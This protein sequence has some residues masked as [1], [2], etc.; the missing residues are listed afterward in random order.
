MRSIARVAR[1]LGLTRPIVDRRFLANWRGL[2]AGRVGG[3]SWSFARPS[4]AGEAL[5]RS[6]ADV[7]RGQRSRYDAASAQSSGRSTLRAGVSA[8]R[9]GYV[10]LD[11]RYDTVTPGIIC[12]FQPL[13][14]RTLRPQASSEESNQK[15]TSFTARQ[16]NV[17]QANRSARL[18]SSLA[19]DRQ[20]CL[21]VEDQEQS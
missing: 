11:R 8:R 18:G 9:R 5:M 21:H 19:Q 15:Q 7:G 20:A 6:P 17:S 12:A 1:V 3:C 4:F 2:R 14:V 10:C 13:A 16:R